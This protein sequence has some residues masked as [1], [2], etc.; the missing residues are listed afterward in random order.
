M[1]K[2]MSEQLKAEFHQNEE[3]RAVATA[4]LQYTS[5]GYQAIEDAA[6]AMMAGR[7][8][9]W[10]HEAELRGGLREGQTLEDFPLDIG[11]AFV[12]ADQHPLIGEFEDGKIPSITV[13][14]AQE[15]ARVLLGE[16]ARSPETAEPIYRGIHLK[17]WDGQDEGTLAHTLTT[18][19]SSI[20]LGVESFTHSADVAQTFAEGRGGGMQGLGS[21]KSSWVIETEGPHVGINVAAL[22]TW[23]QQ[24]EVLT[25]GRFVVDRVEFSRAPMSDRANTQGR[26]PK[27]MFAG[28]GRIYLRQE[29]VF[30]P[31]S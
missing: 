18:P 7:E 16:I 22:S 30:D 25:S 24:A 8:H 6:A 15:G 2:R 12:D 4:A 13:G 19:G 27:W 17:N 9:D 10:A 31:N 29:A 28:G 26:D 14:A 1:G 20:T 3:F 21:N 23:P 11:P 5:G